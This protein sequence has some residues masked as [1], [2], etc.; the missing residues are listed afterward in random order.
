MHHV[1]G[2]F[3]FPV[4]PLPDGPGFL[5]G[6][7]VGDQFCS[8]QV[9]QIPDQAK[10]A[11]STGSTVLRTTA[12]RMARSRRCAHFLTHPFRCLP[13]GLPRLRRA[14]ATRRGLDD[15]AGALRAGNEWPRTRP[16]RTVNACWP[17][18]G[19]A[20]ES[21]RAVPGLGQEHSC[22]NRSRWGSPR[23]FATGF[24]SA[25]DS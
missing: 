24:G 20:G 23:R 17:C 12:Q 1:C 25:R 2:G 16:D 11:R 4:S 21:V 14:T 10:G 7:D 19:L 18:R 8:Q 15:A 3:P 22:L 9:P 13:C 6:T 5:H